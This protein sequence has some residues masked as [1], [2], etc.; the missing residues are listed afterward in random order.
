M[1][2]ML[3]TEIAKLR[4]MPA[5]AKQIEEFKPE[6]DPLAQKE[7]ELHVLLYL[8]RKYS[9]SKLKAKRI[10]LMFS[11]NRLKQLLSK[12]KHGILIVEQILKISTSWRKRAA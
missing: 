5:L 3:L 4:K 7:R 9:M 11:S 10:K 12:L 1:T 2:R 6:P 8:K